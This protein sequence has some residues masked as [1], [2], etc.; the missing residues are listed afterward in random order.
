MILLKNYT[1]LTDRNRKSPL[2]HFSVTLGSMNHRACC[3]MLPLHVSQEESPKE[4]FKKYCIRGA[5]SKLF[6]FCDR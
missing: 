3:D 1:T 5:F 4:A 2:S 6:S